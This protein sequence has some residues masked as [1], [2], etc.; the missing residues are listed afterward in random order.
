MKDKK[1]FNYI[2]IAA[3][4]F[5]PFIYSFFYLNAYWDPYGKGNIDNIPVAIVNSDKGE[6]GQDIVDKI[7]DSEKLKISV[8][9]YKSAEDGLYDKTYYAIINIPSDFTESLE[10]VD[11]KERRHA[12]I[13]YSPNQKSNYLA[14][15]IINN[16]I[17]NVEMN[18]DN[19][20]NS[21]IIDKLSDSLN[22]GV[23]SL[24]TVSEG[25]G[26]L[27]KGTDKL[28]NGSSELNKGSNALK[29]NY[30]EFD[31]GVG[32]IRDGINNI[33][34]NLS[35]FD[36]LDKGVQEIL[37]GSKALQNG[38]NQFTQG[39]ESYINGVDSVVDYS[40]TLAILID[41]NVC[42]KIS[43]GVYT[44]EDMM[45]CTIAHGL[46]ETKITMNNSNTLDYLKFNGNLI[47]ESNFSINKGINN[48]NNGLGALNVLPES[49]ASLKVGINTLHDGADKL[50][51][52]SSQIK[53]GINS[54]DDGISSLNSGITT[55]DS[56][57]KNAKNKLSQNI[58]KTKKDINELDG[59][60]EFTDNTVKVETKEVN[61]VASY[62]TAFAPFFI[63]I[64]LWV[65]CLMLYIIFYYDKDERFAKLSI[66]NKDYTKRTL[67]Y[68][69]LATSA[70][71][72]LGIMLQLFLN[73]NITNIFLY[74][75]S[76]ILVANTFVAIMELLI[77]NLGDIGKFVA[78]ILLVL[79]LAAAGGTFPI[80]TVTSGYRWLH[81]ILP[82]TYTIN[83][84]KEC[85]VTIESNLLV[86]SISVLLVIF[87]VLFIINI[88]N[89]ILKDKKV[90]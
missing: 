72:V 5:I 34:E 2:I 73:F 36:N 12:T 74:Y 65:G 52:S 23:D 27:S 51:N 63:S 20:V 67:L 18:L 19:T 85:L 35:K 58:D 45:M 62:G 87:I 55:L 30:N 8:V 10:S 76:I 22:E 84:L 71:I 39:L 13:T 40:K 50:K 53:I 77:V 48:L 59:L 56:S 70:G 6:K 16:V 81:N 82:M 3:V 43:S 78:L 7:K 33:N 32:S 17:T 21:E 11:S 42:T 46:L 86:S 37:A 47:K 44:E 14:S 15:Q 80:E 66:N 64:A 61:E 54:I 28:K 68:H 38:S 57:V 25:F 24:G 4:L 49:V 89:S 83:L 41:K 79:Q 75:L 88:V 9:D 1:I 31:A 69:L 26:V 90:K 29:L 60:G